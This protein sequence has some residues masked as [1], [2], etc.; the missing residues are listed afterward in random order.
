MKIILL[1]FLIILFSNITFA[2]TEVTEISFK[3]S[4]G[5]DNDELLDLIHS[6]EDD[7]FEPRLIKLDKILLNNFFRK[8]GYLLVDVSDSLYY[9]KKRTEVRIKYIIDTGPRYYYGGVRFEGEKELTEEQ[10]SKPFKDIE[11]GSPF[12]ESLVIEARKRVE[13]IYYNSGKPFV[14]VKSDFRFEQDS[15]VFAFIQ[16]K[17]NQTIYIKKIKYSGLNIVK[18]F[19][20]RRELEVHK[21]DMYNREALEKSQQN[22]YGTGLFRFVRLEIDPIPDNPENVILKII[23]QE[24]DARWIGVN[25]GVGHEEFYGSTAEVT[26]QGGHRNLFGTARSASLHITPSFL[27]EFKTN[28]FINAKNKVAF[29]FVEPWIGYTRTPGIFQLSYEQFRLESTGKFNLLQTSFEVHHKFFNNIEISGTVSA[30]YLTVLNSDSIDI[31]NL[32]GIEVG[33]SEIY[34]LSSYA[35]RDTRENLFNPAKGS[36]TDFSISFSQSVSNSDSLLNQNNRYFTLT[37][38][39]SRFQPWRIKIGRSKFKWTLASRLK[40]G[41]I[42]EIGKTKSIPIS[43][44]FYAGGATTVR[45]YSEQLL[46]PV[47]SLDKNGKINVAAGGK[48]LLLG[49]IEARI[50]LFWLLMG[51]VFFDAG[52][53]WAGLNDFDAREIRYTSGVGI[54]ILTPLGPVRVYYGYKLNKRSVDAD[55]DAFH[56]GIYFAF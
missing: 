29:K 48:L 52:N 15:L 54:A 47:A 38:S 1:I 53:V 42:F 22:I 5:F 46:G 27:Y 28:R 13:N 56:L 31:K 24:R 20:I 7:E 6:Q 45:G 43:E 33:Q 50:P 10:L 51:E 44:R 32:V 8:N 9:F 2:A 37:T 19:L 12:D 49:N 36:L 17:E 40:A 26:L 4:S 25:F 55:N 23:V 3:Q 14:S 41:A 39:W 34:S 11:I 16:I 35:K 21:G 18:K 30:K